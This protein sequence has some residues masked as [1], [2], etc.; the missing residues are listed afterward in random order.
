M[1]NSQVLRLDAN[2]QEIAGGH[3]SLK[4]SF[5]NL[6]PILTDGI[7][8]ILRG[9]A[10]QRSQE[11]DNLVIDDLRNFL[12]G[13]PG[14]GGLDLPALNIQRGRDHGIGTLNQVRSALRLRPYRSFAE[15]NPNTMPKPASAS[16][17]STSA[18][19][20]SPRTITSIKPLLNCPRGRIFETVCIQAGAWP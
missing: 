20:P 10:F 5:F 18:E 14:S 15:I 17:G 16:I 4:D 11:V 7:D 9:F 2:R 1:V 13:A 3:L 12:F 6:Q 19:G 8:P